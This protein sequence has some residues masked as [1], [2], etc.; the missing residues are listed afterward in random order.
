M[1]FLRFQQGKNNLDP[2]SSEVEMWEGFSFTRA[3]IYYKVLRFGSMSYKLSTCGKA[4]RNKKVKA[5]VNVH[6][7]N[8]IDM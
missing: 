8:D 6:V 2:N 7:C 4:K 5:I 1:S 3:K